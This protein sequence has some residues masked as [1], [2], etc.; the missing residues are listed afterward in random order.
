MGRNRTEGPKNLA[1]VIDNPRF[2]RVFVT[3]GNNRM[4]M[5]ISAASFEVIAA[6]F[7]RRGYAVEK[8]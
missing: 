2:M 1:K 8:A 5:N 3:K 7:A 4:P 6:G